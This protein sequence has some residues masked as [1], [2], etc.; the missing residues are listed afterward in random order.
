MYRTRTLR[1][2]TFLKHLFFK[3]SVIYRYILLHA[4]VSLFYQRSQG[5]NALSDLFKAPL[6]NSLFYIDRESNDFVLM[7]TVPLNAGFTELC[8]PFKLH[9][10]A[11]AGSYFQVNK[12]DKKT[13]FMELEEKKQELKSR[14]NIGQYHNSKLIL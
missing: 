13:C 8:S 12:L 1:S 4:Q 9:F 6:I 3:G 10:L 7:Q 2:N 14:V 5:L 11:A